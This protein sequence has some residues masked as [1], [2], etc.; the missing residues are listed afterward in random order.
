MSN[1]DRVWQRLLQGRRRAR[2]GQELPR[3]RKGQKPGTPRPALPQGQDFLRGLPTLRN[4]YP[5][6]LWTIGNVESIIAVC[7]LVHQFVVHQLA[8]H[9]YS[10]PPFGYALFT[11]QN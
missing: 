1:G 11:S 8:V 4:R 9:Q 10:R 5:K 7:T 2:D 6:R 3:D